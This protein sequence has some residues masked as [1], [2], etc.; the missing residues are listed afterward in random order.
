MSRA[1][2]RSKIENLK[3]DIKQLQVKLNE[4]RGAFGRPIA[5]VVG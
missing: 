5:R 2:Q 4:V 1:E 3:E